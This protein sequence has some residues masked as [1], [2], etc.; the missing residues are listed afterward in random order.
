MILIIPT[1]SVAEE[2]CISN[3]VIDLNMYEN[4]GSGIFP[5]HKSSHQ[6]NKG[7]FAKEGDILYVES[8]YARINNISCFKGSWPKRTIRIELEKPMSSEH[9]N[10]DITLYPYNG[11]NYE[12]RMDLSDL[13]FRDGGL[14]SD[15]S[16][17]SNMLINSV[18][19]NEVGTWDIKIIYLD[20]EGISGFNLKNSGEL[21]DDGEIDVEP[22]LSVILIDSVQDMARNSGW[23]SAFAIIVALFIGGGTIWYIKKETME[24]QL[25]LV[26]SLYSELHMISDPKHTFKLNKKKYKL[27]GN[28]EWFKETIKNTGKFPAHEVWYINTSEYIGKLNRK[29]NNVQTFNLKKMIILINQKILMING[30]RKGIVPFKKKDLIED[31]KEVIGMV[32]DAKNF[33]EEKFPETR[34]S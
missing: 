3:L 1:I 33:I 23:T 8:L 9:K 15:S 21:I 27:K 34:S 18:V 31:I 4:E 7:G 2:L 16:G 10:I 28:L 14:Y 11:S 20:K 5:I 26:N 17:H 29:I 22:R 19:L 12:Y 30:A 24:R 25:S 13:N 6:P 32:N